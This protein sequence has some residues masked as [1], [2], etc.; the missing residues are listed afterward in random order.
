MRPSYQAKPRLSYWPLEEEAH[1]PKRILELE[2]M[3]MIGVA[4]LSLD[5][6]CL[7][8]YEDAAVALLALR[9]HHVARLREKVDH[10]VTV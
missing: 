7:Q 9:K 8:V 4:P 2:N 10:A 1:P 3:K 5:V 6:G